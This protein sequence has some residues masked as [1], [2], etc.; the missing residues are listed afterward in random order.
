[1]A[2]ILYPALQAPPLTPAQE[3]ETT[4]LDRW[5]RPFSEPILVRAITAAVI[6]SGCAFVPAAPFPETTTVSRWQQPLS[7]PARS[8]PGLSAAAQSFAAPDPFP[9]APA[10]EAIT[11]DKWLVAL[12]E[13]VR[14]KV[15]LAAPN[16]PFAAYVGAAP[17]AEATSLDRWYAPFS[18]PVRLKQALGIAAQPYLFKPDALPPAPET[19]TVDKWHAALSGPVRFRVLPTALYPFHVTPE[20]L[21][22]PN[23][24]IAPTGGMVKTKLKPKKRWHTLP[25]GMRVLATDERHARLAAFHGET[26][27][28]IAPEAAA[29]PAQAAPEARGTETALQAP[30]APPSRAEPITGPLLGET[31]PALA[32]GE[33]RNLG[34]LAHQL[35]QA[36]EALK[37]AQV[38]RAQ[39]A[40]DD[41]L[42]LSLLLN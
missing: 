3:P 15:S 12:S 38:R 32:T 24:I 33:T 28:E 36:G 17:F 8:R 1:M 29:E 40:E 21:P 4:S 7:E 41:E 31:A 39:I 30:E 23:P 16:Q 27:R 34:G 18:E 14:S 22:P 20:E 9:R 37:A 35:E 25:N 10:V 42:I 26:G 19:I 2:R 5:Y 6:A 13:P 11:V